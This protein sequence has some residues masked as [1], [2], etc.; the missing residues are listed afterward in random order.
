MYNSNQVVATYI[1]GFRET[2]FLTCI[3]SIPKPFLRP[4]SMLTMTL[5]KLAR[6]P[7]TNTFL[8]QNLHSFNSIFYL[9]ATPNQATTTNSPQKGYSYLRPKRTQAL[10]VAEF[11]AHDD[12]TTPAPKYAST[13]TT[14]AGRLGRLASTH[15]AGGLAWDAAAA[16][17]MFTFASHLE[18]W[19]LRL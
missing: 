11:H 14:N 5:L 3:Q 13:C 8:R 7:Q 17:E 2:F 18:V 9:T 19:E 6:W 4:N 12:I 15:P 10:F 1:N 16:A